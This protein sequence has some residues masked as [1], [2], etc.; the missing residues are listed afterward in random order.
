VPFPDVAAPSGRRGGQHGAGGICFAPFYPAATVT[1]ERRRGWT[2]APVRLERDARRVAASRNVD[3][4]GRS[5]DP[6]TSHR[7]F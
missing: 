4:V 2:R 1:R 5:G 3:A 6:G 7:Q